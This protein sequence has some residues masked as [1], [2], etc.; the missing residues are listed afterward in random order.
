[1]QAIVSG[2]NKMFG[3]GKNTIGDK[4]RLFKCNHP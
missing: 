2:A 4:N 1:M 3:V